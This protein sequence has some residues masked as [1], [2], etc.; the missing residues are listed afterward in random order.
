MDFFEFFWNTQ[1]PNKMYED[2]FQVYLQCMC[3]FK[4]DKNQMN[5]AFF[6]EEEYTLAYELK[7]SYYSL[8]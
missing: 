2:I 8:F 5:G 1:K 4:Q 6:Q 3:G 7:L